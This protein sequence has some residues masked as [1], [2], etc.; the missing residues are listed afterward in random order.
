MRRAQVWTFFEKQCPCVSCIFY[1]SSLLT[2]IYANHY[3]T[4]EYIVEH[5]P[6]PL[7]F[8]A[9]CPENIFLLCL[10]HN[11]ELIHPTPPNT[12][13]E[14]LHAESYPQQLWIQL[15]NHYRLTPLDRRLK[16]NINSNLPWTLQLPGYLLQDIEI[17]I[18]PAECQ[19]WISMLNDPPFQS[20]IPTTYQNELLLHMD[21]QN[22]L[23]QQRMD[24]YDQQLESFWQKGK[25]Y[26]K[27]ID[28]YLRNERDTIL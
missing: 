28:Q 1:N 2:Y 8:L 4:L 9:H 7:D 11:D 3:S 13:R 22:A 21:R 27:E 17:N 25:L 19:I 12:L 26:E 14:I 24:R 5:S 10:L 15:Y 20:A 16:D 23:W 18:H 6:L